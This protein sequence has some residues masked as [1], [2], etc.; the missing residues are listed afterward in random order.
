ASSPGVIRRISTSREAPPPA[1]LP[2]AE[3]EAA[4][5]TESAVNDAN[6]AEAEEPVDFSAYG[7]NMP[8]M[9]GRGPGRV[10]RPLT[11]ESPR[12]FRGALAARPTGVI[13]GKEPLRLL[14]A[15]IRGLPHNPSSRTATRIESAFKRTMPHFALGPFGYPSFEA[16]LLTAIEAGVI[17]GEGGTYWLPEESPLPPAPVSSASPSPGRPR[18]ASPQEQAIANFLS[19]PE[20]QQRW[21]VQQMAEIEGRAKFLTQRYLARGLTYGRPPIP[22]TEIEAEE[23]VFASRKLRLL[24][25]IESPFEDGPRFTLRVNRDHPFVQ[26]ALG[27]DPLPD[28]EESTLGAA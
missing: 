27:G 6:E 22:L 17:R 10:S 24:N 21:L 19:L 12:R 26:A 7:P 8:T 16:F 1:P 25:E 5:A 15:A 9:F 23:L 28:L 11:T 2:R 13:T 4:G 18:G 20:A 14:P 3:A